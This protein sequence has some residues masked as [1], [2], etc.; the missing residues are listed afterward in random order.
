MLVTL[1]YEVH[2]LGGQITGCALFLALF[3]LLDDSSFVVRPARANAVL[4]GLL[5]AAICTQRQNYL[6]AA[7]GVVAFF[8]LLRAAYLGRSER[9]LWLRQGAMAGAATIACLLPWCALA[10]ATTR[11]AFYPLMNGNVN[12]A[13]GVVGMVAFADE[14]KWMLWL[15]FR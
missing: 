14:L 11:T 2:D 4:V 12:R 6:A 8:Y 9:R 1:P 7:V 15:L 13:F 10:F 5:A 3:R